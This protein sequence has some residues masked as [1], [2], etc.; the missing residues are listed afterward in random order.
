AELANVQAA[1][2]A[3]TA[4]RGEEEDRRADAIAELFDWTQDHQEAVEAFFLD[5]AEEDEDF[6]VEDDDES[7]EEEGDSSELLAAF[8]EWLSEATE[9]MRDDVEAEEENDIAMYA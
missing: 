8:Y 4:A 2:D 7:A 1:A 3:A 5:D 9:P 6:E